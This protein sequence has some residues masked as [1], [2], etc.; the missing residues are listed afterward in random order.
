MWLKAAGDA[1]VPDGH[2]TGAMFATHSMALIGQPFLLG[3]LLS[4]APNVAVIVIGAFCLVCAAAFFLA[5]R[6]T[7]LSE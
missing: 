5:T 2:A 1:G 7:S 6:K 3:A 4:A